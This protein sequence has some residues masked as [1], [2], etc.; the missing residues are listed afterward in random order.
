MRLSE[1]A[2]PIIS[3]NKGII[4]VI[5]SEHPEVDFFTQIDLGILTTIASMTSSKLQQIRSKVE[6][7]DHKESLQEKIN[8]QTDQLNEIIRELQY[9]NEELK[10]KEK[11]K[12]ILLKEIHHRVKNNLQ[13][14]S[15]LLSLQSSYVENKKAFLDCQLR[16]LSMSAIHEQLY[17]KDHFGYIDMNSYIEDLCL[18]LPTSMLQVEEITFCFDV[19]DLSFDIDTAV[20]IGLI[21]TE[22]ITNSL[23]HAFK[24]A[25]GKDYCKIGF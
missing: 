9:R 23:K 17:L 18:R 5:D 7:E 12:A 25:D 3:S 8:E 11:E 19:Q 13:I 20:P 6:L 15:S 24:G 10:E 14:V 1:I 21:I 16:I 2:V 22:L 4:G